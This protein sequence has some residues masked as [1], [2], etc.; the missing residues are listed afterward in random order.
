MVGRFATDSGMAGNGTDPQK[1]KKKTK[2]K[3]K[4]HS[5]TLVLCQ[6]TV[7]LSPDFSLV[8]VFALAL[9]FLEGAENRM[10]PGIGLQ[11]EIGRM[12]GLIRDKE[13]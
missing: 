5:Q 10:V 8:L 1:N 13:R 6:L 3:F 2:L 4:Q 9:D 11:K 7:E 12:W